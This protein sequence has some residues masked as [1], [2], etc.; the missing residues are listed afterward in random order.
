EEERLNWRSAA[1]LHDL[2]GR[3]RIVADQE[4][5]EPAAG[6]EIG[7]EAID[8]HGDDVG[9]EPA[10]DL[11]HPLG[12][13]HHGADRR[14]ATRPA[15]HTDIGPTELGEGGV[16]VAAGIEI[17]GVLALFNLLLFDDGL[18]Q[19]ALVGEVN[20]ECTLGDSGGAGDLAHAGAVK[21]Q[22]HEYLTGALQDLAAL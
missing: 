17:E 20:V 6:F 11:R 9:V 13:R 16:D 4:L 5:A 3:E 18:E 2:R 12:N 19:P 10:A 21:T 8:G 15:Q 1:H 7:G 14:A 22:I